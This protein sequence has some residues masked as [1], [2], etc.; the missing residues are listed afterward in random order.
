MNIK[1]IKGGEQNNFSW[2]RSISCRARKE[3]HNWAKKLKL[4]LQLSYKFR[5][6]C[7]EL[8]EKSTFSVQ[9]YANVLVYKD[10]VAGPVLEKLKKNKK[11]FRSRLRVSLTLN[12]FENIKYWN[13]IN[14]E[15]CLVLNWMKKKLNDKPIAKDLVDF[16]FPM[17]QFGSMIKISLPINWTFSSKYILI[18]IVHTALKIFK[19]QISL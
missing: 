15:F 9:T 14:L 4:T 11:R 16:S 12:Q 19:N 17:I 3:T 18:Y 10:S 13:E 6:G 2:R 7:K 8:R 5:W 1:Q